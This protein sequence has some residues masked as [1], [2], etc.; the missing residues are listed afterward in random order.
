MNRRRFAAL[1][2]TRALGIA[3]LAQTGC[4]SSTRVEVDNTS[5][6]PLADED[7]QRAM[8]LV[9]ARYRDLPFADPLEETRQ[10]FAFLRGRPEFR[11]VRAMRGGV[12][13][14][15]HDGL[16]MA[17]ARNRNPAPESS[18]WRIGRR[19]T[20]AIDQLPSA[21]R[22]RVLN[23]LGPA[24]AAADATGVVAEILAERGYAV[25]AV[26]AMSVAELERLDG[27]DGVVFIQSH[28]LADEAGTEF[29]LW[30]SDVVTPANRRALQPLIAAGYVWPM[31]AEHD[32]VGGRVV[33]AWHWAVKL[34]WLRENV[35]FGRNAF[36]FVNACSSRGMEETAF[37]R[38]AALFGG[39]TQ[40]AESL[41]AARTALL[42]VDR[43]TGRNAV[44]PPT[45]PAHAQ[46]WNE[47]LGVLAGLSPTIGNHTTSL[48]ATE[49]QIHGNIL[50]NSATAVLNPS[51]RTLEPNRP[52]RTIALGG[53]F[54]DDPGAAGKVELEGAALA[55]RSWTPTRIVA[56]L[57]RSDASGRVKVF[58]HD[59]P[60][61]ALVLP[62]ENGGG[63]GN[64]ANWPGT[65]QGPN[66][67]DLRG[68]GSTQTRNMR[69]VTT[70]DGNGKVR[71]VFGAYGTGAEGE[72]VFQPYWDIPDARIV[73]LDD[74]SV[75]LNGGGI[76]SGDSQF[77]GS[78]GFFAF[79]RS[80]AGAAVEANWQVSGNGGIYP[81]YG[82]GAM[83]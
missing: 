69:L 28:G 46:D 60:S 13:F 38:G 78:S 43:M 29:A 71:A 15:L 34:R 31:L 64:P 81:I 49:F 72:D 44:F 16:P 24:F 21:P 62:Q 4:G 59:R 63:G 23:A 61:N 65:I 74:G 80:A 26:D 40:P 25:E 11:N 30:T 57:P 77:V 2:T 42:V 33:P 83:A 27:T 6:R 68:I 10:M 9:A 20:R 36:V 48:G 54:G 8:D 5:P 45:P 17:I 14:A 12:A 66:T 22:A 47:V 50:Q 32:V 37:A 53:I 70:T 41:V 76:A 82:S 7:V 51:L 67:F 73:A 1:L 75:E 56:T 58:V 35:A 55:V 19:K 79:Y 3:A 18:E 52:E 39:W